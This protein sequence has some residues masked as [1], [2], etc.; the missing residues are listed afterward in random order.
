MVVDCADKCRNSRWLQGHDVGVVVDY[1]LTWCHLLGGYHD[2]VVNDT[3]HD[4]DLGH[5]W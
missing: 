4:T 2:G 5:F 3:G 1:M